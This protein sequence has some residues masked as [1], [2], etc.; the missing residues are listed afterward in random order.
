[1]AIDSA[2]AKPVRSKIDLISLK[3]VSNYGGYLFYWQTYWFPGVC[4]TH[5]PSH[6]IKPLNILLPDTCQS[7][8]SLS[9]HSDTTGS[10][11][12]LP[13]K[14]CSS[15]K[16]TN[17]SFSALLY[18]IWHSH[19]FKKK[20]YQWPHSYLLCFLLSCLLLFRIDS[21]RQ[22][23]SEFLETTIFP[24]HQHSFPR[25]FHPWLTQLIKTHLKNISGCFLRIFP[26]C[27]SPRAV[28]EVGWGRLF[29]SP[30]V[31]FL[32]T[33]TDQALHESSSQAWQEMPKDRGWG[34][35]GRDFHF[36]WEKN[37]DKFTQV[38]L[39]W[40]GWFHNGDHIQQLKMPEN[41]LYNNQKKKKSKN[42]PTPKWLSHPQPSMDKGR[43]KRQFLKSCLLLSPD[44]KY[45]ITQSP[46]KQTPS[47]AFPSL[48]MNIWFCRCRDPPLHFPNIL[49]FFLSFT[50]VVKPSTFPWKKQDTHWGRSSSVGKIT[51]KMR[52]GD[53]HKHLHK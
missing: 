39:H 42:K 3:F 24:L 22:E 44:I 12:T 19:L 10:D 41:F 32:E 40:K 11:T 26:S 29:S 6:G 45:P 38:R 31:S 33:H 30:S 21:P 8:Q 51:M 27:I 2:N 52:V 9:S 34:R 16:E 37:H 47:I 4:L 43:Q 53:L 1:M 13:W 23:T 28:R 7:Y 20:I 49:P 14:A 18:L 36:E 46:K 25:S 50:A 17:T 35:L 15:T 48:P 5:R